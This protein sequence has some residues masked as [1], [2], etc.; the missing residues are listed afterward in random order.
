MPSQFRSY[1]VDRKFISLLG[2]L[3]DTT[4]SKLFNVSVEKI[5]QERRRRGIPVYKQKKKK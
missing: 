4:L 1:E 5:R 3:S 2:V